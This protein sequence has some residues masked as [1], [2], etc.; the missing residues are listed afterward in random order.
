MFN[1][2]MEENQVKS[3]NFPEIASGPV[4]STAKNGNFLILNLHHDTSFKWIFAQHESWRSCSPI[5]K[6]SKNI[7]IPCVVVKIWSNHFHQFLNFNKP[8]LSNHKAK[9]GG[10]FSYKPHF[11]SSFQKYRFH[12]LKPYQLKWHF[13]TFFI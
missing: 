6:K 7:K 8:Y 1:L 12:D 4:I 5:F 11:S 13:W 9:F 10:V 3:E 2:I